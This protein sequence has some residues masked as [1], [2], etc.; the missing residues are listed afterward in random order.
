MPVGKVGGGV[1]DGLSPR[2]LIHRHR[3]HIRPGCTIR[4]ILDNHSAHTSKETRTYL[5][6]RPN[7]FRYVL[8]PT[9][10]SWPNLA[11]T[12]FGK[13]ARTFLKHIRVQSLQELHQRI[14]KGID[15]I[16]QMP[17]VHRWKAFQALEESDMI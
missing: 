15:E 8:T 11:E 4:L 5:A 16:N 3:D 10:G 2:L 9:H 17:V 12:L 1:F 13:M 14:M 7:R 6:T